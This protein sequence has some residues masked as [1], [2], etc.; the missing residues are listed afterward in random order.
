A[1]A[2][3]DKD[4]RQFLQEYYVAYRGELAHMIQRG[5]ER[6]EFRAVDAQSTAIT[7]TALFEGLALLYF[8]D[9]QRVQWAEQIE[10]SVQLVLDGLQQPV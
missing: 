7:L 6:G 9:P 5:I 3:R 10:M 8:V 4:V 1:I 2:G